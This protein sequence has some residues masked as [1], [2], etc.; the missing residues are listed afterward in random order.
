[1]KEKGI[2]LLAV[3]IIILIA[4]IGGGFAYLEST[5]SIDVIKSKSTSTTIIATT[6]KITTSTT[7]QAGTTTTAAG[8]TSQTTNSEGVQIKITAPI[9]N[10]LVSSPLSVKGTALNLFENTC[11]ARLKDG[12]GTVLAT[13][14]ITTN[15]PDMGQWGT[16]DITLTFSTPTTPT[17]TLEVFEESPATGNEVGK[18]IVKIKFQ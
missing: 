6:T 14:A 17:G 3:L 11:V 8:G 10:Q 12:N 5:G 7:V 15:A 9:A 4:V 18:V 1:M 16:I 2:V 13:K